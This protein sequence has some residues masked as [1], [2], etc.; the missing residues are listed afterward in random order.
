LNLYDI[1]TNISIAVPVELIP[2]GT[3]SGSTW[4][5]TSAT[6][7]PG[8]SEQFIG[9]LYE[10]SLDSATWDVLALYDIRWGVE[11]YD[12]SGNLI[13]ST[14]SKYLNG[15]KFIASNSISMTSPS[16]GSTLSQTDAAP[17]FQWDTYQGVSTYTLI[18]AHMG[19][20]GFDSMITQD[21][22]I[23]NLYPM[24]ASTWQTMPTGNWYWTVFGY[25]S[26]GALTPSDF[27]I[28]NFEVQ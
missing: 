4:G 6:G 2:P 14:A 5:G 21:N 24:N 8:F 27:T 11:A 17:S 7:T 23:L 26:S 22:L 18:L 15:L 20:L 19:N 25:T 12:V 16:N 28:F 9:M 1:L 13:G 3:S 10:L